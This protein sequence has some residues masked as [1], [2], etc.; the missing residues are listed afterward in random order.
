MP[1]SARRPFRAGVEMPI[2]FT[3]TDVEKLEQLFGVTV[4][5][6]NTQRMKG[7][8]K[9]FRGIKVRRKDIKKAVRPGRDGPQ[10]PDDWIAATVAKAG[11]V[12]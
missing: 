4:R 2:R 10:I 11:S 1:F 8:T 3:T 7:K 5:A 9:R 6:V 12:A